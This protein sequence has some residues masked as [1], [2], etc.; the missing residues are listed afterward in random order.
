MNVV[1]R[2]AKARNVRFNVFLQ[3]KASVAGLWHINITIP[4]AEH[5]FILF[6]R[7]DHASALNAAMLLSCGDVAG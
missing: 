4:H 2:P 7:I 6:S 5:T 1:M 3:I